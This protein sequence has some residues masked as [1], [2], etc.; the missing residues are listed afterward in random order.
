MTEFLKMCSSWDSDDDDERDD[1]YVEKI[2]M[3]D[4]S[5]DVLI[6]NKKL[7]NNTPLI[8]KSLSVQAP[9]KGQRETGLDT[10]TMKQSARSVLRQDAEL[11]R[12]CVFTTSV[13]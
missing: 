4:N 11:L 6:S 7:R 12:W 1:Q 10:K 5:L 3:K 9:Y 13:T 2:V 8:P